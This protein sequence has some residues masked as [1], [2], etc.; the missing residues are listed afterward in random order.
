MANKHKYP[1]INSPGFDGLYILLPGFAALGITILLPEQ[2][3]TSDTMPLIGW[4]ILILLIDV[5]HVYST[6]FRTY[7]NKSNFSKHKSLYTIIPLACYTV[8]VLLYSI[9]AMLFWSTLAYL[10][11]FHFIR[12]QYGIM[13]LYTRTEPRNT[14]SS[15]LNSAVIYAA[16]LYP[17]IY[18]HCTP[19][20]NF[21]WFIAG[22][23]HITD[24]VLL[25]Q[26]SLY[27]YISI[28]VVYAAN[29]MYTLLRS[30]TFNLPKN[31]VITGTTLTWYFGIVFFNGDLTFTLLNVV[32]HGI[33]YMAL[34]WAFDRKEKKQTASTLSRPILLQLLFFL[35]AI[36]LLAYLEEGLWDGLIWKEHSS[37]FMVFNKLPSISGKEA[38]AFLVPLLSLPQATHYV[39]DGFIWKKPSIGKVQTSV[40][41]KP[42]ISQ[43]L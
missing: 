30:G 23:F 38:L 35:S 17:I 15:K 21:N 41:E 9:N 31:L 42:P 16:T 1:W 24:A 27:V 22:D 2:Y 36:F 26:I 5:A 10:A 43:Y 11:V 33:P 25:K 8:S 20:R 34:I 39:L 32:S 14:F 4:I 18:W 6:L 12:Q 29:E 28:M 13:R 40:K 37:L 3:K 7:W 19:G